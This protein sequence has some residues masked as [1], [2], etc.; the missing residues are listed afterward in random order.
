MGSYCSKDPNSL[1]AFREGVLKAM[2]GRG[3]QDTW[4]ALVQ[5][6][7][8][9]ASRSSFKHH[10]PS[11]FNQSSVYVVIVNR[12]H[13]VGVCFLEK[14]LGDL[15]E[16]FVSTFQGTGSSETAGWSIVYIVTSFPVQQVFFDAPSSRLLIIHSWAI[17]LRLKEDKKHF[18]SKERDRGT[19]I[20]LQSPFSLIFLNL[21]GNRF[22]KRKGVKL[23]TERF[24]RNSAEEL[25]FIETQ[26]QVLLSSS[27][28]WCK[29]KAQRGEATCARSQS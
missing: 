21:E 3:L 17:F 28:D 15:C 18:T 25:S 9:L 27:S 29:T 19:C 8:W 2:W 12:F 7:D 13:L 16:A 20:W 26:F 6:S 4:S 5:F 1:T 10:Q 23:R 11:G 14:Q 22:R 24:I